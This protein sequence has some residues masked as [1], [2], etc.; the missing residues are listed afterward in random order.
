MKLS[1][2][3]LAELSQVLLD[4]FS[5]AQFDRMLQFQLGIVR[6][7]IALGSEFE[8]I[9]FLV[10]NNFQR[11]EKTT[12]LVSA[13]TRANPDN[14][15]LF[16][17]AQVVGLAPTTLVGKGGNLNPTT[18]QSLLQR[19]VRSTNSLLDIAQWRKR[20]FEVEQQVCR[21]EIKTNSEASYGT[22]FL[23]GPDVVMTNYHVMKPVIN[24]QI[25]PEA[26]KFRFDY[27]IMEDGDTINSG[28]IYRLSKKEPWEIDSSEYSEVDE[29]LNAGDAVPDLKQLDYALVRLDDSPGNRPVDPNA[30]PGATPRGWIKVSSQTYIFDADTA[31][32]IVQ[33]PQGEPLK[34]ALDT[35]AVIGVNSNRTRVRYYT[36]TAKGS[37]GSPCFNKD[38]ELVALHHS[39][40][41]NYESL[42]KAEYNQGIPTDMIY[43]LL[44]QRSKEKN[45]G[46]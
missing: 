25:G 39:G 2:R 27:K 43:N 15:T 9:V 35:E 11:R 33:H 17:F 7:H 26:V 24:K 6:E 44:Q 5:L 13:A 45:L 46:N 4:S 14:Q 42:R 40:D 38:W 36:N 20:L 21:V 3:R 34:M 19:E 10:L 30:R 28:A 22:G 8:E 1:N 31:L 41:P 32:H 18:D 16:A 37:S 29:M 23:V 12:D